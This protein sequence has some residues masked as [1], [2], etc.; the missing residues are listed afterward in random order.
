MAA[1]RLTLPATLAVRPL[2]EPR[3][4]QVWGPLG[5]G[6]ARRSG[7]GKNREWGYRREPGASAAETRSTES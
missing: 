2:A 4:S 5:D 3:L 6:P 1:R 7:P